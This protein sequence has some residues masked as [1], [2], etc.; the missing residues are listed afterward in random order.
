VSLASF[1][2][3][4]SD[5]ETTNKNFYFVRRNGLGPLRVAGE[6]HAETFYSVY[7]KRADKYNKVFIALM[8]VGIILPFLSMLILVPIVTSL[9]KTN[10]KV[11][12][13]FGFIPTDEIN[14]LANKCERFIL[15][16]LEDR[17]ERRDFSFDCIF[18]LKVKLNYF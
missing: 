4:S 13:M 5:Y 15:T 17:S 12:S 1:N 2:N 6:N 11:L 10:K 14:E 7:R 3:A 16:H 8:V 18:F 9:Q